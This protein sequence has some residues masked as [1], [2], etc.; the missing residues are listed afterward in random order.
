M[1][2]KFTYENLSSLQVFKYYCTHHCMLYRIQHFC[3][4]Y[5]IIVVSYTEL[6]THYCTLYLYFIKEY[7]IEIESLENGKW[8]PFKAD[9]VQLEVFRIDPFIRTALKA[10]SMFFNTFYSFWFFFSQEFV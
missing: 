5:S 10:S 7:S 1:L 2:S 3:T 9:D 6:C 4:H 8:I